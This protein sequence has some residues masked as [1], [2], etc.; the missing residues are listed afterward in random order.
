MS[1]ADDLSRVAEALPSV[2]LIRGDAVKL[3]PV[4]WL[5]HGFLPAGM[6]SIL[7]GAPGCGKT[8]IALSLAATLTRGGT[9]PDGS[10][11]KEPCDVLIWSGEDAQ[12]VTAARL[13]AS[14]ADL[15]RVQFIDGVS[16][17]GAFDPARDMELLESAAAKLDA[18]RLL[19]L[20]PI[21]S[22]VAGDSHKNAEVRKALQPV[23]DMAHR[24]GCAVLG[25]TH[26]SKG[27]SGR[28]PIERITGSLAFAA[29]ARL[30]LVAAK[31]KPEPGNEGEPR[32]VLVRAKSNIGPDDGGFA[33]SLE[34][35]EVAPEVEGQRVR[36]L[37]ALDGSARDVL[38]DA[39]DDSDDGEAGSATDDAAEFLRDLLKGTESTPSKDATRRM[40]A[41]GYSD[42]VIRCAR[43]R[44]GVV[45]KRQGFGKDMQSLWSMPLLPLAIHSCPVAPT[46]FDGQEWARM[47]G[48][49]RNERAEDD[50]VAI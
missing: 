26:F 19:I 18:P 34:R 21:V 6:L 11:C 2:R 50:E 33:Y 4:R 36:W 37:E 20:D 14:G 38:A 47:E 7:G 16:D 31:V 42:K 28:D 32:R 25:I 23:V 22:A 44:L 48:V 10:R 35:L 17:G 8:T 46:Q 3:E 45:V 24:L 41:E 30:V 43:E 39:E 5:W 29:L 9:W 13:V 27:T 1:A 12:P 49:G 40:K 15:A